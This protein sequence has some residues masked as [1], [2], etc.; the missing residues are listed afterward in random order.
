MCELDEISDLHCHGGFTYAENTLTIPGYSYVNEHEKKWV[1]GWDYGHHMDWTT[2][3]PEAIQKEFGF[4]KWT[5]QE[6]LDE[7]RRV[8]DS[9]IEYNKMD[10]GR[11]KCLIQTNLKKKW[12]TTKEN[13]KKKD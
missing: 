9:I 1:I 8:I 5:T 2:L 7:C 10:G 3:I 4:K 12:K 11:Y 6:V 13:E